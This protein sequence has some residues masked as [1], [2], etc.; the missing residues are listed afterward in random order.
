MLVYTYE[1][2]CKKNDNGKA[3]GSADR[4]ELQRKTT[5]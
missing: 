2:N 4:H 3:F 5:T 1:K